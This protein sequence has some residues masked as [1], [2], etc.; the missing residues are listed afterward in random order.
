MSNSETCFSLKHHFSVTFSTSHNE[1]SSAHSNRFALKRF[2]AL[3]Q[4]PELTFA[5]RHFLAGNK[6]TFHFAALGK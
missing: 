2:S 4:L 5:Y 6:P 1:K 3:Q